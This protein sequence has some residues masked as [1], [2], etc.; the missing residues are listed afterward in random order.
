MRM[1]ES[2][3]NR[4]GDS[5]LPSVILAWTQLVIT[6]CSGLSSNPRPLESVCRQLDFSGSVR[7]RFEVTCRSGM[8]RLNT[9]IL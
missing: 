7:V 9:V 2:S 1:A 4:V 8:Y 5:V 6:K 3:T